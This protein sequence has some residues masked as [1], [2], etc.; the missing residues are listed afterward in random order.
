MLSC[1]PWMT[2]PEDHARREDT[3]SRPAGTFSKFRGKSTRHAGIWG[4]A[5]SGLPTRNIAYEF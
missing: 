5:W 3:Y 4:V 2:G 1:A